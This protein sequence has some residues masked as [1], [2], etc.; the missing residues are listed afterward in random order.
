MPR[1]ECVRT[2]IASRSRSHK[3]RRQRG[4]KW[5]SG[6]GNMY[7]NRIAGV[8][9]ASKSTRAD[10][11]V[12]RINL[13]IAY[14]GSACCFKPF[15]PPH[16]S[17]SFPPTTSAHRRPILDHNLTKMSSSTSI[18]MKESDVTA[19]T[20]Q[21]TPL[22]AAPITLGLSRPTVPAI[23]EEGG[24]DDEPEEVT[25][26][27]AVNILSSIAQRKLQALVGQS[28][29]YV[30]SLPEEVKRSVEGLKGVQQKTNEIYAQYKKECWEL[31]KKVRC[32]TS[33]ARSNQRE[34]TCI[35]YL[36]DH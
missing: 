32:V 16:Q 27:G 9:A 19:P 17:F 24:D 23:A 14:A 25:A 35:I 20:P 28:S 15:D 8:D 18:P 1:G 33:F 5:I 4:Q 13:S 22:N 10:E 3:V 6:V 31:E 7:F 2:Q 21:N 30:E 34:E 12:T 29:G 26:P 11:R 36:I